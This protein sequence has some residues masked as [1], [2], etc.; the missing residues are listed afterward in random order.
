M[1]TDAPPDYVTVAESS[2]TAQFLSLQV[3]S[4]DGPRNYK[5]Y[6]PSRYDKSRPAPLL[7][8][9]HGCTQDPDDIAKGTRFNAIAEEKGFLVAYPEQPQKYNG[10]KCWN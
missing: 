10:L 2:D 7:V 5:L 4:E 1:M 9:L 3:T 6:V 8:V